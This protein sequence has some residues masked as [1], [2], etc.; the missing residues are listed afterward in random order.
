[1][2]KT[3]L[4]L[5]INRR[6]TM[7]ALTL[8]LG[9]FVVWGIDHIRVEVG[10]D[11]ILS[12][13]DPYRQ[14]VEQA[15]I[16]FP[17][18]TSVLFAFEVESDVFNFNTLRAIEALTN[19]YSEVDTAISVA[20][21]LNYRLNS[22]DQDSYAR[23]YLIPELN[24]LAEADLA[25][26]RAIALADE[27]LTKHSLS[28]DGSL[29][30]A[31]IRF[32]NSDDTQAARLRIAD[33]VI[34]LRDSLREQYP[35]VNIYVLGQ[36]LFERDSYQATIK[37]NQVLLPLITLIGIGL[38]WFCLN[39]LSYAICL[40]LVAAASVALTLGAYSW[41]D[42]PLN[43]ISRLGPIVVAVV[44]LADGI[45]IASVYSQGLLQGM[46]RVPAMRESLR[47]NLNPISL[48]TITTS[49][50]FLS[51]NYCS[52]PGI[53]GFGNIIAMGVWWALL[54]TLTLLP[55]MM[56]LLPASKTARPLSI[57][58]FIK[59]VLNMLEKHGKP[60]LW[61]GAAI[62]IVTFA[63]LPLN[64][65]DFDRFAF[66]DEDSD[67]HFILQGLR[68][69]IGNDQVLVYVI[70]SDGYYGITNPE[71]LGKVD[72]FASWLEQ[73]Q[74][75]SFVVSYTDY[76]RSRY[77]G[78]HEDDEAFDR[79]PEDQLTI[80]DY[81][82]GYQ[83]VQEIEPSLQPMFNGDYSAIRLVVATS[84]LSNGQLLSLAERIDTRIER[85]R[86]DAFQ[87]T[88]GDNSILF[89]RVERMIVTELMQ[90]FIASFILITIT[91]MIGL[92]SFRYGLLSIMPNL[93]PATIVFGIWGVLVGELSPYILMLFSISIGLVVDDSV[94]IL[95]KYMSA[96]REGASPWNAVNYSIDRAGSAITITTLS[97]AIG[98][99]LIVF[100]S[101]NL[102]QNVAKLLSPIIIVALLL[103][104]LFLP[105]LLMKFDRW[106]HPEQY[107]QGLAL[108][109]K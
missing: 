61:G 77:K 25:Q 26:L 1:M 14:E 5:L 32:K 3:L 86:S 66:V 63:L 38:L 18:A 99:F 30:L 19:R 105:L 22:S 89:A 27:D 43:Q 85:G 17:P 57:Q 68:E 52:S 46:G 24:T 72:T 78:D 31:T 55:A 64:K 104:L 67:T 98:T 76:L 2:S 37:D 9:A 88:R 39:S 92:R 91:M 8:F 83:L 16:D 74:D 65:M 20:S 101:T 84:N 35:E 49:M 69:K 96:K 36:V 109:N 73:Q 90:G 70:R 50:G 80:I 108:S 54:V 21:L 40:Y 29:S 94:H 103:D 12:E 44:A 47:I 62:I 41:M 100:S 58:P 33:S 15:A 82:V 59:W 51:L 71:F 75:V 4:E 34:A 7:A 45:H 102:F 48:A 79:L 11:A 13:T 42:I 81:L 107:D 10:V 28:Q 95:S 56:L 97:L 6:L 23:D 106:L 53:Y 93:F 87:I 60:L